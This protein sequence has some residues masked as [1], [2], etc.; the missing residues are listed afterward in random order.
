MDSIY[1]SKVD[2]WLGAIVLTLFGGGLLS[3]CAGIYS[4]F[5]GD[6]TI[7]PWSMLAAGLGTVSFILVLV[8]P[9]E[10]RLTQ[11]E[12]IIK[13]GLI[14]WKY[15][16]GMITGARPT[17]N[18]LSSPALS[19]DRIRIEYKG[20]MGFFMISPIDKETFLK[21]LANRAIHLSYKNGVVEIS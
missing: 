17:K 14:R 2:W 5:Y 10:Y 11:S 13:S 9:I 18:P 20:K 15:P 21:D 16:Y 3:V 8:Y 19:L 1:K 12:I 4:L 7:V 6:S